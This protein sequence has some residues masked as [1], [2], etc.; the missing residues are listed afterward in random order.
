MIANFILAT[1]KRN[2]LINNGYKIYI[3]SFRKEPIYS[4][5]I[6]N[7]SG[8]RFLNFKGYRYTTEIIFRN[9][10]TS[11]LSDFL[12]LNNTII[13]FKEDVTD[14][15]TH[16]MN[17]VVELKNY[18]EKKYYIEVIFK[19]STFQTAEETAIDRKQI[20]NPLNNFDNSIKYITSIFDSTGATLLKYF[21]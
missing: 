20:V 16:K 2:I 3:K 17:C 12:D 8:K 9:I 13:D 18:Q 10:Q 5:F 6:S 11:D 19:L 7:L 14:T 15:I 4:F 21:E 1:Y